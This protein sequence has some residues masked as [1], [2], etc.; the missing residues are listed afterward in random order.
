M[1]TEE[2]KDDDG[3]GSTN[4]SRNNGKYGCMGSE[5]WVNNGSGGDV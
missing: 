5:Q 2:W 4:G 3:H 1:E